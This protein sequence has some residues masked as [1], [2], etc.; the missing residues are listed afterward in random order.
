MQNARIFVLG[1]LLFVL[2]LGC[3]EIAAGA[4]SS[5]LFQFKFD[6]RQPLVYSVENKTQQMTDNHAG[7]RSQ[8]TRSTVETR[9]KVKLTAVNR[10]QD[11]TTTVH[12]EPFDFEQESQVNGAGGQID[13]TTRGLTILSKQNGIVLVDTEKGIGQAQSQNMKQAI[14]PQL[15]TGYF[16]F[17]PTGYIKCFQGE[18]PFVDKW[19]TSLKYYTNFFNIV[20]PTNAIAVHEGWTNYYSLKTAGPVVF[21]GD[22]IVQPWYYFRELDQTNGK[23]AVAC[24][25]LYESDNC[26]DLGG[27]LDQLG[28]QTIIDVPEHTGSMNIAFKFDQK[29]GCL[30]STKESFRTHDD[31]T[32]MIQGNPAESHSESQMDVS[33]TLVSP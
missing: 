15:L 24:F 10:N 31:T 26:K 9:F 8:L 32:M 14:Y 18:L 7:Q 17:E 22:G 5:Q 28:Q 11:G 13:T 20:F 23:E 29:R 25:T 33:I 30:I 6:L 1:S 4:D 19:Q 3:A 16:V 27:Y 12:F 21:N 2:T